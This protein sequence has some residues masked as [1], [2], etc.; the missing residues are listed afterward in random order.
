M[1][2]RHSQG[3]LQAGSA[4][5]GLISWLGAWE[6]IIERAQKA[7]YRSVTSRKVHEYNFVR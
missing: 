4:L 6:A 5:F 3:G 7:D 2:H 1:V